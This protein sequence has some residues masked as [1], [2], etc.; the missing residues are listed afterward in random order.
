MS[1][2]ALCARLHD[3]LLKGFS[4]AAYRTKPIPIP[5]LVLV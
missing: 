4:Y 3:L 2:T 5:I 1:D